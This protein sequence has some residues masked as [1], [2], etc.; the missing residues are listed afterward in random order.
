MS[1]SKTIKVLTL[2]KYY[3]RDNG[4][5]P[6]NQSNIYA[7]MDPPVEAI[8]AGKAIALPHGKF[9][10]DLILK[11]LPSGWWPDLVSISSTLMLVQNPPIPVGIPS[12]TCPS[13]MKLIDSHHMPRPIQ[14]LIEYAKLVGCQY[15]WT[16]Y[17]RHHIHFFVE[18]GLPNVFWMPGAISI[19]PYVPE[20]V[21]DKTYDVI[22]RG[23]VDSNHYHRRE[24]LKFLQEAEI[25]VDFSGSPYAECLDIYVQSKIVLN[26]SL[27]GDLN[28]RVYE[29]L[30]VGG[31]LLTDRLALQSG[32]PLLFQEGVHLECYGS[33][34]ELL[35][36][37]KYYLSHPDAA[38]E[39]ARQGHEL[40][41]A[42]YHPEILVEKFNQIVF[43]GK[44]IPSI[45]SAQ[46]DVRVTNIFNRTI[47]IN[48]LYS[49]LKIYELL[50]EV[51]RLNFE[52]DLLYYRGKNELLIADLSDLP[53]FQI[54]SVD[55][56]QELANTTKDFEVIIIDLPNE[57]SD[58]KHLIEQLNPCL[59]GCSLFL[60]L[61]IS[62]SIKQKK[63]NSLLKSKGLV[64]TQFVERDNR[65]YL[66]YQ[67]QFEENQTLSRTKKLN[68]E[69][70]RYSDIED[71]N[72]PLNN[73]SGGIKQ[74]VK[75][76]VHTINMR[77]G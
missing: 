65:T 10:I 66:A 49:R 39:I 38:A 41:M 70:F 6:E 48:N 50:Q 33:K 59:S 37:I 57:V 43:D 64:P 9:K 14:N 71:Y 61:G 72:N 21:K 7:C 22:F 55:S 69:L 47:N 36:K 26:C 30:M 11:Q 56:S 3:P 77:K 60:A 73:S 63:L 27:N 42:K 12:L 5:I 4:F 1:S 18:A 68:L 67:R 29:V 8:E 20:S 17:T 74:L 32:L 52:I 46:D 23:A 40:F 35:D 76:L 15:H 44:S 19:P 25:N 24:F 75:N 2:S 16:G 45:F 53:K 31:F 51:H 54:T 34:Q 62:S 13:V 58:L 28:R